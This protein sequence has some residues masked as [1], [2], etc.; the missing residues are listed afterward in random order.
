MNSLLLGYDA[1]GGKI[2]L[3]EEERRTHMHVI[4]SSGSGKSKLLEWMMRGDL[5]NYQGFCLIDP[6]GTLY[7]AVANY[8]AH[9]V[10][11]RDVIFLNLSE[12]NDIIAFNPFRRLPHGDL[13]VQVDRRV[14]ATMHAWNVRNT[15]ETPTLGRTL[16]LVYTVLIEQGL[17][18]PQASPLIDFEEKRLRTLLVDRTASALVQQEWEELMKL[19][20]RE[21][22]EEVLS[23]KNRLFRLI[24]S[25]TLS[26]FMGM[27]AAGLDLQAIMDEGKVLLINLRRS[28]HLSEENAR[29]FGA[30]VVHEFF[31][32]AFRREQDAFGRDPKPYYL[33]LDEFQNFV[34]LDIAGM[35]DQVRKFGLYLTLAHQRFGQL[36]EDVVEA[37]LSHCHIKA[38]FGGLTVPNA[39]RM[40]EE[41]FIGKLDPKKVKAAIYQTKFW[42]KYERDRVY[43][44]GSSHGTSSTVGTQSGSGRVEGSAS[45][46]HAAYASGFFQA[47]DWIGAP[48]GSGFNSTDTFGSSEARSSGSSDFDS[49]SDSEGWMDTESESV[50][51]I[52]IFVPVPFEELSSVQYY[53]IE[54]QLIELTAA[55][56]RQYPRHCFIEIH[57]REAQ[58]MLVPFVEEPYTPPS[59]VRWYLQK[60]LAAQNALPA[61]EADRLIK[62][63]DEALRARLTQAE[64]DEAQEAKQT[65]EDYYE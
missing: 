13:G 48:S 54:E 53:T 19:T 52:P 29:V 58:P 18:L 44:K 24:N 34:S 38:V 4:G 65:K 36:D 39:K 49:T 3:T 17:T 43:T 31:E 7:D 42:P 22:R 10:L 12:P 23:A 40:A 15:D 64:S 57:Q 51:D 56:K 27:P 59:S 63:A 6:H 37:A 20:R 33:Y 5:R 32:A 11:K 8:A 16:R 41:L 50:A 14:A 9:H 26:R 35:L 55:L 28:D 45:G 46:S 21:W 2:R 61:A 47:N 1:L 60:M 25:T 62:E 30:F